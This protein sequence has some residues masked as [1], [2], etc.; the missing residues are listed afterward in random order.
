[1][2]LAKR[3]Y[4]NFCRNKIKYF[5]VTENMKIFEYFLIHFHHLR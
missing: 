2:K 1:M 4:N 3:Y 5:V